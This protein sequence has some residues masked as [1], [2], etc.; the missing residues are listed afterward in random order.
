MININT[1]PKNV[2]FIEIATWI[3]LC[4]LLFVAVLAPVLQSG[5]YNDDVLNSLTFEI[6]HSKFNGS[7]TEMI[8]FY[9]YGWAV[10]S[11]RLFPMAFAS[12]YSAFYFFG[13]DPLYIKLLSIGFVLLVSLSACR[14]VYSLTGSRSTALLTLL[15]LPIT[16]QTR[17]GNEPILSNVPMLLISLIFIFE[18]AIAFDTHCKT[19]RLSV[20]L[21]SLTLLALGLLTY[22]VSM[23]AILL[24]GVV[25]LKHRVGL[26]KAIRLS[27]LHISVIM[28]YLV[29]VLILRRNATQVYEG[30]AIGSLSGALK[31]FLIN[32]YA[33]LPFSYWLSDPHGIFSG[34]RFM[35]DADKLMIYLLLGVLFLTLWTLL[36][37]SV[38][39][40]RES[41]KTGGGYQWPLISGLLLM[42]LPAMLMASSARYQQEINQFGQAHLAAL[43]QSF[44]AAIVVATGCSWGIERLRSRRLLWGLSLAVGILLSLAPS[45]SRSNHEAVIAIQNRG[46]ETWSRELFVGALRAGLLESVPDG[47]QLVFDRIPYWLQPELVPMFS[48]KHVTMKSLADANTALL[49]ASYSK[50]S[51][52]KPE[53]PIFH[54]RW[55]NLCTTGME[56]CVTCGVVAIAQV[57]VFEDRSRDGSIK[58]RIVEKDL[59]AFGK[60]QAF[61]AVRLRLSGFPVSDGR[62]LERVSLPLLYDGLCKSA[63]LWHR[64]RCRDAAVVYGD[65]TLSTEEIKKGWGAAVF[66]AR[67]EKHR[68]AQIRDWTVDS[69]SITSH[70][71]VPDA[72]HKVIGTGRYIDDDCNGFRFENSANTGITISGLSMKIP[73][74]ISFWVKPTGKQMQSATIISNHSAFKGITLE[75]DGSAD[76]SRYLFGVGNGREWILGR[77][78]NIEPDLWSLVII[79]AGKDGV[80]SAIY[81]KAETARF[82]IPGAIILGEVP[83]HFGNWIGD[84][85]AFNGLITGIEISQGEIP[86]QLP[87]RI[88]DGG[89]CYGKR[90]H[91]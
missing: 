59:I 32:L 85:R 70:T 90:W 8:R 39:A 75:Q 10:N 43:C 30:V 14:F 53:K 35:I 34:R 49:E 77:P 81:N 58:N 33:G 65:L 55:Q 38:I 87:E 66:G 27:Y 67:T 73:F 45:L 24:N 86:Q 51:G 4:L 23:I 52:T 12:V 76:R 61:P 11:G 91:P 78:F 41:G 22:E 5:F 69:I 36:I 1:K 57:K 13:W 2:S 47:A 84:E 56:N 25:L 31:S 62:V 15:L 16:I 26:K 83:L 89:P 63:S 72:G 7:L 40:H 37:R 60:T 21:Y 46:F 50:G 88:S 64:W 48:G 82:D 19:G 17:I 28:A 20:L 44:G 29:I 9:S 42:I 54:V 79:K 74:V 71:T 3:A 68:F 18:Q 80:Q 6:V